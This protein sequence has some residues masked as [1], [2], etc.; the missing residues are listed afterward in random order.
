[1]I[2]TDLFTRWF[3]HFVHFVKPTTDYPVLLIV[4]ARYPHM[5]YLDG[6]DKARE[7]GVAIVSLPPHSTQKCSHQMVVS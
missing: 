2:Q 3:D 1:V 7:H 6:V 4:D 5:K